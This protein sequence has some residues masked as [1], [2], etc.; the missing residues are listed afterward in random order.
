MSLVVPFSNVV[1]PPN[2]RL[3]E[4]LTVSTTAR[5]VR[6]LAMSQAG[7][8]EQ[9]EIGQPAARDASEVVRSAEEPRGIRGGR[10][11]RLRWRQPA[12]TSH[13]SSS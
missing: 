8:I 9:H 10:P 6:V 13:P 11:K 12:R 5:T 4:Q 3:I 7:R 1:Q 2:R